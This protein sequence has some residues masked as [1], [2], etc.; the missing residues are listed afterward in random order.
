M[1]TKLVSPTGEKEIE[2]SSPLMWTSFLGPLYFAYHRI[3]LHVAISAVLSVLTYGI[4][5]L[6]YPFFA[7][8]IVMQ[9]YK[10][11]GW[12]VKGQ[13]K[14]QE[15]DQAIKAVYISDKKK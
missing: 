12:T 6:V 13:E 8:N 14:A 2:I 7:E 9:H 3:W 4:S 10:S 1:T 15:V 11:M 5:V